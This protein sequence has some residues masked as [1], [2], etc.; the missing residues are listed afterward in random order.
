MAHTS[1]SHIAPID[2]YA[3]LSSFHLISS[4]LNSIL[5]PMFQSK[6]YTIVTSY[7]YF[8]GYEVSS[9]WN[10]LLIVWSWCDLNL[11]ILK[12]MLAVI[13]DLNLILYV[14]I[15][16]SILIQQL[17]LLFLIYKLCEYQQLSTT[18]LLYRSRWH[19][20]LRVSLWKIKK[21]PWMSWIN[22][23]RLYHCYTYEY[24]SWSVRYCFIR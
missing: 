11:I 15:F 9:T 14:F 24:R 3:I 18:N 10:P 6:L 1:L 5:T 21:I 16:D 4:S 8:F 19:L 22:R 13:E 2:F 20:Q 12:P 23:D 17:S 7:I